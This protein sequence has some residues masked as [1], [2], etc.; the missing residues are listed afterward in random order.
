MASHSRQ[1]GAG[2]VQRFGADLGVVTEQFSGCR[3]IPSMRL[4]DCQGRWRRTIRRGLAPGRGGHG[5][6]ILE[7]VLGRSQG[8]AGALEWVDVGA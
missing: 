8:L 3:A 1:S 7:G 4:I 5:L 2:Y 6:L